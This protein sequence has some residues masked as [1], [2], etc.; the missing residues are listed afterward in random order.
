MLFLR[1]YSVLGVTLQSDPSHSEPLLDL[2]L[3]LFQT[4]GSANSKDLYKEQQQKVT[5]EK[6]QLN[7]DV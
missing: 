3:R 2:F 5:V 4:A 1:Q 6:I 7:V